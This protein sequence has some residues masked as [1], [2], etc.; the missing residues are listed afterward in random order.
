MLL[1]TIAYETPLVL[2]YVRISV[3][4]VMQERVIILFIDP[5]GVDHIAQL[6]TGQHKGKVTIWEITCHPS[7]TADLPA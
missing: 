6:F 2:P 3:Q 1:L 5:L 7:L 4:S